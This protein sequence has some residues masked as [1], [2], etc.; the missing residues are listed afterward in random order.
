MFGNLEEQQAKMA[1]KLGQIKLSAEAGDGQIRIDCNAAG[2]V[3]NV[4]IDPSLLEAQDAE[5]LEDLM[6][7]VM[8]RAFT[9]VKETEAREANSMLKDMLPPGMGG[10]FGQ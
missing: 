8:N 4:S 6:I 9:L 2:L 1:E 10:L 5:Q 7:T 3:E